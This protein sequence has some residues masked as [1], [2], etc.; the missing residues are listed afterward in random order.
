[1]IWKSGIVQLL[2]HISCFNGSLIGV[3]NLLKTFKRH[4][5]LSWR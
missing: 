2:K 1:M 4:S 3:P 5:S